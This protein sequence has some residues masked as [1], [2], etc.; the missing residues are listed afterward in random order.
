MCYR[1]NDCFMIPV[2][3]VV[4]RCSKPTKGHSI[5]RMHLKTGKKS[6][7]IVKSEQF[8]LTGMVYIDKITA[9]D[10]GTEGNDTETPG[11]DGDG[12]DDTNGGENNNKDKDKDEDGNG[13]K[14]GKGDKDRN[15]NG[16]GSTQD[17]E[18]D[19]SSDNQY[20]NST[21]DGDG[22]TSDKTAGM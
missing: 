10:L 19:S 8:P 4:L 11:K 9:T 7:V 5:Q 13:D 18:G 14:N 1:R 21:K 3:T 17:Q 22:S 15:K 2:V 6:E 16:T 12:Q 20:G